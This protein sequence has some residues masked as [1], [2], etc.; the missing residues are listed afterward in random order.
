MARESRVG[1]WNVGT[2]RHV[3]L[4]AMLFVLAACAEPLQTRGTPTLSE[5]AIF[6]YCEGQGHDSA[7]PAFSQCVEDVKGS[8]I[9]RRKVAKAM[10][11]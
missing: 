1:G 3:G 10:V 9:L 2:M 5:Q 8:E 11:R 4:Y 7:S 6:T